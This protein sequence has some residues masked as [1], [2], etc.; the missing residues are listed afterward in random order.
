[1]AIPNSTAFDI[2]T[3]APRFSFVSGSVFSSD[4]RWLAGS[5][6]IL[7]TSTTYVYDVA[8]GQMQ[9]SF[10]GYSPIFS[11]DS[12]FLAVGGDAV[13]E[14]ATGEKIINDIKL[15]LS[16]NPDSTLIAIWG[17][18]M[19]YELPSGIPRFT[20]DGREPVF[21][22]TGEL[23]AVADDGVYEVPSGAVRFKIGDGNG[24]PV[25]SPDGKLLA[26]A[27]DYVYDTTIG[28]RHL[29]S[30]RLQKPGRF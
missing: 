12:I 6:D 7:G 8:T 13:Y 26:I 5:R 16:F 25:F 21:D 10:N 23:L 2:E 4:G 20:F 9:F 28:T 19:V 27:N 30:G 17:N 24:I 18:D 11:P 29:F 22:P 3:G 14:I 1:M 15:N